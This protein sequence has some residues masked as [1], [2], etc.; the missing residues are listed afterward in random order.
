MPGEIK[1]K[2]H[3]AL[4]SV[5]TSAILTRQNGKWFAVFHV[6]VAAA[7]QREDE[8]VGIDLGL[9]SL[10]AL[11]TGETVERPG[12]TKRAAKGLR[13][14]QRAL[15]R[16]RRGSKRRIKVRARLSVYQGR[17]G[18]HRADFAHKLTAGLVTRFSD[19][20]VEDLNVKGLARGMLAKHVN[21]AA[22]T[23][24]VSMLDYKAA[25]A[26]GRIVKV[27]P[28]GTSQTCPDCGI[29]AAKTLA[30]REHRC[31]CGCSLDRD[32]AAAIIV[33]QRAFGFCPGTGLGTSS[34][35]GAA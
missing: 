12:W 26:G 24:I 31:E 4:P 11:S 18:R 8:T 34:G 15:A 7:E 29:I 2:W 14:R 28:R 6:E 22:W 5:P 17:I 25:K 32:V 16:C 27:D 10:I 9:T 19:I 23:Q 20:G 1:V 33:H 21:D 3:R 35:P 13:R 30:I